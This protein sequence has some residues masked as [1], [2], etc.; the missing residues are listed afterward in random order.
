MR[1][2]SPHPV[3]A[4]P[5]AFTLVELL[6]VIGIIALLIGVL[7][8]TLSSAQRSARDVKCQSNIRQLCAALVNYAVEYKGKF[9]PNANAGGFG[10]GHPT[11]EQVWFHE[12]RIGRFLPKTIVLGTGNIATPVMVCPEDLEPVARS[13]AMN[14]WASGAVDNSV[15]NSPRGTLWGSST[16]GSSNLI[17]ITEKWSGIGALGTNFAG[18]TVGLQGDRAGQRFGA[19]GGVSPPL[20]NGRFGTT[21]TEIDYMRHRRRNDPGRGT[22]PKGRINIGFADGHV[23]SF[24]HSDLANFTDPAGRSRL[25]ALWSPRDRQIP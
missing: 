5:P 8:P 16:K 24:Q 13:Y 20:N 22:E 12:D 10:G 3:S 25:V 2:G 17:L 18:A 6:V 9:P 14:I 11:T 23:Q 19:G 1:Q 4:R 15:K 21:I 7:L